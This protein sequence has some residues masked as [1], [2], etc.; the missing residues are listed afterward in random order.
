M[1]KSMRDLYE[2]CRSYRRFRREPVPEDVLKE[3]VEVAAGRSCARNQQVLKFYV[4]NSKEIVGRMQPL[5]RYAAALPPEI[6][7]PGP[8][9]QPQAFIIITRPHDNA[10]SWVDL[11][12]ALDSL[13]ITAWSHGV[14]S[15]IMAAINRSEIADLLNENIAGA[16]ID[17]SDIA[18]AVALGYPS[19][20]SETVAVPAD[21]SLDYYVDNELNYYVPKKSPDEVISWL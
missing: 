20:T 6:G 11:G 1:E 7:T 21:G 19:I 9:A 15:L 8:D 3:A 18:V 10:M 16:E 17:S 4:L 13:A 14:G 12:I 5:V 2:S